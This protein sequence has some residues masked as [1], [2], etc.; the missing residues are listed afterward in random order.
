MPPPKVT[1][2]TRPIA[3][4]DRLPKGIPKNKVKSNLPGLKKRLKK[5]K[6][7]EG[8][9]PKIPKITASFISKNPA[10]TETRNLPMTKLTQPT[11]CSSTQDQDCLIVLARESPEHP[12]VKEVLP[13]D[14]PDLHEPGDPA[15]NH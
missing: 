8:Q 13:H 2:T 12:D 7:V 6:K 11:S 9:T 4:S 10:L 5:C 15:T 14:L 3:R 1:P